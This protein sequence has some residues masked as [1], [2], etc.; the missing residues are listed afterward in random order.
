MI[1]HIVL[2]KLKEGITPEQTQAVHDGLIALKEK[3]TIPGLETITSG[4]NNSPEGKSK[5]FEWG[6]TIR[7]TDVAAR[8][9]Y[10]PH[11]DHKELGATF[12]RPIVEDVFVFDYEA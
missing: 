8:D 6:F 11:P 3:G 5:D 4:Y 1:E 9:F 12:I 2:L 10:L 7:F